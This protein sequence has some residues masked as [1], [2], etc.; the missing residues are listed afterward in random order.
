MKI[1]IQAPPDFSSMVPP[2]VASQG[3]P[4]PPTSD[5][6]SI[7]NLSPEQANSIPDDGEAKV[8]FKKTHHRSEKTIH[9]D[10]SST[11]KHHVR[12]ALTHFHPQKEEK[13]GADEE[14]APKKS[15]KLQR[16]AQ[17]A[18]ADHFGP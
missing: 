12:L 6:V 3:E 5:G 14:E 16:N 18:V 4:P 7:D 17:Q 13:E 15:K 9:P 10:G 11:E 2:D 8:G 1:P